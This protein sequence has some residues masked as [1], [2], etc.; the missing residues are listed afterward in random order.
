MS[1]YS[2]PEALEIELIRSLFETPLP[3]LL[4]TSCFLMAGSLTV[5]QTGDPLLAL[6]LT[7]GL[8]LSAGRVALL[9]IR[10]P[11]M[12]AP[13]LTIAHARDVQR[14][15][16]VSYFGF[17]IVLGM[18][19]E[20]T[21]QLPYPE[22]HMLIISLLI[23]YGAGVAAGIGLRPRIA[24]PS[25]LVASVP[26]AVTTYSHP[27][28][29]YWA[30]GFMI[31]AFL[32]GGIRSV[33]SRHARAVKSIGRRIAF[34]ALARQDGLTALPNRL[35]LRE[36]YDEHVT[37]TPR[38]GM[39]AVHYLDLNGFKPVNDEYGHPIG[40]TLLIAVGKRIARTIRDTDMAARFGGDEFAIV[41]CGISG[42]EEAAQLAQRLTA[43]IARPYRIE[44]HT[45]H[46]STCVGYVVS[47]GAVDLEYLLGIA[48]EALYASKRR[49]GGV[50]RREPMPI[51]QCA[52]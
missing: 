11:E 40:D 10:S 52:A 43:A 12:R 16:T 18:F 46:I 31:S 36:W 23:G 34:S 3:A 50:T 51:A 8:F 24:V 29:V 27:D 7:T 41:Q 28:P 49:G 17:A 9:L 35:A 37:F 30:I 13:D 4:M 39:L 2:Q 21:M 33:R 44:E 15:F 19:G 6:L 32:I 25:M 5:R 1:Q 22:L 38:P 14:R 48:D 20:R 47:Q 26:T 42:E 45:I